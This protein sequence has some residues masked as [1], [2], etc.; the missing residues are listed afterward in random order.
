MSIIFPNFGYY[1]YGHIRPHRCAQV[2]DPKYTQ[3]FESLK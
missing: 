1:K 3:F 2:M